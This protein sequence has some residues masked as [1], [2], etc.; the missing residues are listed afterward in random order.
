MLIL[1]KQFIDQDHKEAPHK[2]DDDVKEPAP[3]NKQPEHVSHVYTK[4]SKIIGRALG[5]I[6]S[7]CVPFIYGRYRYWRY[8]KFELFILDLRDWIPSISRLVPSSSDDL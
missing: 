1:K 8:K 5:L 3:G 6:N 2:K 4:Y 7:L